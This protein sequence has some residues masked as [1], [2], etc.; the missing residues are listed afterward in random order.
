MLAERQVLARHGHVAHIL[1]NQRVDGHSG[2]PKKRLV[3]I[4][5]VDFA[6]QTRLVD[7]VHHH[8]IRVAWLVWLVGLVWLVWIIVSAKRQV[9]ALRQAGIQPGGCVVIKVSQPTLAFVR[10]NNASFVW[11]QL[12]GSGVFVR[13]VDYFVWSG[14][15][16]RTVQFLVVKVVQV[17]PV[18]KQHKQA[19][20]VARQLDIDDQP[21]GLKTTSLKRFDFNILWLVNWNQ[22]RQSIIIIIIRG[23]TT[24]TVIPACAANVRTEPTC[25]T[26]SATTT[27]ATNPAVV[28]ASKGTGTTM[29]PDWPVIPVA[30]TTTTTTTIIPGRIGT[31][32]VV[33]YTT[34]TTSYN[35]CSWNRITITSSTISTSI[36]L[37]C[38]IINFNYGRISSKFWI[39]N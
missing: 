28:M 14:S 17:Q 22:R 26:S 20:G 13:L 11:Q 24:T 3:G 25:V 19:A 1:G 8:V 16:G 31:T 2:R 38:I 6:K 12:H 35:A 29:L 4:L 36:N 32:P 37:Y 33:A 23:T 21:L 9:P 39:I 15:L 34:S 30:V 7:V 27:A 5:L 18:G 10:D